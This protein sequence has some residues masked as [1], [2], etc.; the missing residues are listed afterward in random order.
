MERRA[1]ISGLLLLALLW[2]LPL[3]AAEAVKGKVVSVADGDTITV[4]Q[5][6]TPIKVR[7]HGV[8]APEKA[9]DFGTAARKFTSDLCFG[10]EVTVE[11]T[12]TDRYGRKVG[13]VTLPDGRLLNHELVAAGMAHWYEDYDPDDTTLKQLQADARAA[14]RG[15]WSR[16]DVIPPWEFRKEKREKGPSSTRESAPRPAR[17]VEMPSNSTS[18]SGD[19]VY[20]TETG[21]K[22]HTE[23]CRTL[24]K[25][26]IA[27][28]RDEAVRR[29]YSPCGICH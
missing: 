16:S 5:E 13:K 15:L 3:F 1:W 7:L 4:L 23:G 29:G 11:V 19:T 25:S 27:V 9:Q 21:T 12:D 28:S 24:R 20:I 10:V 17:S 18:G 14:K 26:K 6:K 22:Y 2:S 8:D